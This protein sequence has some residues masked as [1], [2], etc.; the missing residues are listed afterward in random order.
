LELEPKT[1][2]YRKFRLLLEDA[3]TFAEEATSTSSETWTSREGA[4]SRASLLNSALLLESASNA[5]IDTLTLS[6]RLFAD[7]DRM[8][9]LSK[10]EYYL[11]LIHPERHMEKVALVVQQAKESIGLRNLL[12][13]PKPFSR[14][15]KM[16]DEG[17]YRAE[18]GKTQFL[19]LPKTLVYLKHENAITGIKAA[20]G[21]LDYFFRGLCEYPD[22]QVRALLTSDQEYPLPKNV[23]LAHDPKWIDWHERWGVP[24]DFLIDVQY[25]REAEE[26][27]CKHLKEQADQ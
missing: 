19:K 13:H 4:L 3:V 23:S 24:V 11:Q 17:K 26:R 1:F 27:Y 8:T 6:K 22:H 21:F 2:V 16:V 7:V 5:I 10:F 12:V 15:W 25:V 20:M 9:V 14:D 18:L